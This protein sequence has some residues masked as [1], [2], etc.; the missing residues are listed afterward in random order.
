M[1][2]AEFAKK[3]AAQANLPED[4]AVAFVK[5]FSDILADYFK[6]GEKVVLAEFGSFY[7]RE[8]KSIQFN[9]SSRLRDQV[10]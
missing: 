2:K 4:Q 8:D 6:K 1:N 3:L 9:P 5:A 7:I 10:E